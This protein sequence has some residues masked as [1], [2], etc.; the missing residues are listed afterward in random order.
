MSSRDIDEPQQQ[1]ALQAQAPAQ[2][3]ALNNCR[4]ITMEVE[5]VRCLSLLI[6]LPALNKAAGRLSHT[7]CLAA[8]TGVYMQHSLATYQAPLTHLQRNC[9]RS[10]HA[11]DGERG[12]QKPDIS[13]E[14]CCV[15]AVIGSLQPAASRSVAW[16]ACQPCL[17]V[18]H[19]VET[20]SHSALV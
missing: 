18:G 13:P 10:G 5:R 9:S 2:A 16:S 14:S 3:V 4:I 12:K 20:H 7:L 19:R 15:V 8:A 6:L 11:E 1:T 17:S